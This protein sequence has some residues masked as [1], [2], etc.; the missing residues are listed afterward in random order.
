MHTHNLGMFAH[1]FLIIMSQQLPV[2][3]HMFLERVLFPV[4]NV[5]YCIVVEGKE[6]F[7]SPKSNVVPLFAT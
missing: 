2:H 5:L 4:I 1:Q 3:V 6:M 7:A